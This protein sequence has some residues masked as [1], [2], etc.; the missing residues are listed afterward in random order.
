MWTARVDEAIEEVKKAYELDP[1]SLV[2]N[3][4]LGRAFFLARKYDQAIEAL[5]RTIELDP[6][7]GSTH[8]I[9]GMVYFQKSMYEEA[10]AEFQKEKD[11]SARVRERLES[12][13]GITL[14]QMSKRVEAQKVLDNLLLLSKEKYVAASPVARL[15]FALGKI[16]M[17]FKWLEKAVEERENWVWNIKTDPWFDIVRSDLRF[18]AL[19]KKMG[20]EK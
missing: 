12:S 9:L 18:T 10:L 8:L 16:D 3:R 13:I 17:G 15:C 5:Q 2:I 19:L 14:A 6:N 20:L 4:A 11:L 7:F 1:L